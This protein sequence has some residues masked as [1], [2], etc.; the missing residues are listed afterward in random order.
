MFWLNRTN[1]MPK[2]V[3]CYDVDND[4]TLVWNSVLTQSCFPNKKTERRKRVKYLYTTKTINDQSHF[5]HLCL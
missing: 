4:L 1:S 5:H 2:S 3:L